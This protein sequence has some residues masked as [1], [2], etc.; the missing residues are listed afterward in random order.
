[1]GAGGD[2][3]GASDEFHFLH[4]PLEGDGAIE[5]TVEGNNSPND[6]GKA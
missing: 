5:A 3:R 1:M 4:A 6:W 2:V